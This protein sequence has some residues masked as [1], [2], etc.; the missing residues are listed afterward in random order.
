MLPLLYSTYFIITLSRIIA[1]AKASCFSAKPENPLI[2]YSCSWDT[3]V[4]GELVGSTRAE[5]A[6]TDCQ[7]KDV[8]TANVRKILVTSGS[9]SGCSGFS[10]TYTSLITAFK[11]ENKIAVGF[12]ET[13]LTIYLQ[14]S[15]PHFVLPSDFAGGSGDNQFFRRLRAQIIIKPL[16]CSVQQVL[17]C[18][19]PNER[20]AI[21]LKTLAVEIYVTGTFLLS[22][23]DFNA[24][25][26]NVADI[27]T[28]SCINSKSQECCSEADLEKGFGS[29]NCALGA[30]IIFAS[31]ATLEGKKALFTTEMIIDDPNALI[32]D[33]QISDCKFENFFGVDPETE[34]VTFIKINEMPAK[35]S[36]TR[37]QFRN[38]YFLS[39]F[40]KYQQ[41]LS[42]N[43][44]FF[45]FSNYDAL[46][47]ALPS[48]KYTINS[49]IALSDLQILYYNKM[50]IKT[51]GQ[52][53]KSLFE[54]SDWKGKTNL[55]GLVLS[56]L[57]SNH[58]TQYLFK[59]LENSDVILKN[60]QAS[61]VKN[62]GIVHSDLSNVNMSQIS[63]NNYEFSK[64]HCFDFLGSTVFLESSE[65]LSV[66][67]PSET[68]FYFFYGEQTKLNITTT[69]FI[70]WVNLG[71]TIRGGSPLGI[72]SSNFIN[73]TFRYALISND[74]GE[75]YISF[76]N[77]TDI[78]GDFFVIEVRKKNFTI[79]YSHGVRFVSQA[80]VN[81]EDCY[82]QNFSHCSFSQMSGLKSF[83]TSSRFFKNKRVFNTT[84]SDSQMQVLISFYIGNTLNPAIVFD[85][86]TL[87]N[88]VIM[89]Y[90]LEF[91]CTNFTMINSRVQDVIYEETSGR[92]FGV[93]EVYSDYF[94]INT[95]FHNVGWARYPDVN[96][97][98]TRN[99]YRSM[100]FIWFANS[101][102]LRDVEY[103]A[104]KPISM[105]TGLIAIGSFDGWIHVSGLK[106]IL[107]E[108]I[109]D[110]PVRALLIS[111]AV[112]I[113]FENSI[114]NNAACPS[115]SKLLTF[116]HYNGVVGFYNF[117]QYGGEKSNKKW[118][119]LVN[120]TFENC[121]CN[122]GGALTIINYN[123][124]EMKDCVFRN[125]KTEND[126]GHFYI[127]SSNELNI[128]NVNFYNSSAASGA[129]IF[130]SQIVNLII[131]RCNII[132]V[133]GRNSGAS[134]L[135]RVENGIIKDSSFK[136]L[137]LDVSGGAFF[138][139]ETKIYFQ[140]VVIENC[141]ADL[142]GMFFVSFGSSI[143]VVNLK[144]SYSE[145]N[146]GGIF[147]VDE[148]RDFKIMNSSF[149]NIVTRGLSS[150]FHVKAY[151]NLYLKNILIKNSTTQFKGTVLLKTL[152]ADAPSLVE[153][154][155]CSQNKAAS[156]TCIVYEGAAKLVLNRVTVKENEG[157]SA[158]DFNQPSQISSDISHLTISQS[159][160]SYLLLGS[161]L[162]ISLK[163]FTFKNSQLSASGIKL[164]DSSF[165]ISTGL[166]Q[167][168]T[169]STS[170]AA[171]YIFSLF[172]VK[173]K[174]DN[175]QIT[176]S[177][178]LVKMILSLIFA[179]GDSV[180]NNQRLEIGS[181]DEPL[182]PL[183]YL[184]S[185][186]HLFASCSFRNYFSNLLQSLNTNLTL[187]KIT[188]ENTNAPVD[189]DISTSEYFSLVEID[190]LN[191]SKVQGNF[192]QSSGVR[193]ISLRNFT[194]D[195]KLD[196]L[197]VNKKET[198]G[199]TIVDSE[200]ITITGAKMKNL[201]GKYGAAIK[202]ITGDVSS[203]LMKIKIEGS[204]FKNCLSYL[205]GVFITSG[206]LT[207]VITDSIFNNN[208]AI[209]QKAYP[210]RSGIGGVGYI[211]RRSNNIILIENNTFEVNKVENYAST[212]MSEGVL[213]E[214]KNT[215]KGNI[216]ASGFT[217]SIASYP[218]RLK[219]LVIDPLTNMSKLLNPDSTQ[220]NITSGQGFNISFVIEDS[221][222][223]RLLYD[224]LSL[225]SLAEELEGAASDVTIQPNSERSVAGDFFFYDNFP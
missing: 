160:L 90:L 64:Q 205:G 117:P 217:V 85:T 148:T 30:K 50:A 177:D 176:R 202:M 8:Q 206:D 152:Q 55:N 33:L 42:K 225:A 208:T 84:F 199:F 212:I 171:V 13:S 65:F 201:F 22:S 219:I 161:L 126:G 37:V 210:W 163:D 181:F 125:S 60:I 124:I 164:R 97:I 167:D 119:K 74:M 214:K 114:I 135:Y 28:L 143:D 216:D 26:S 34:I 58:E 59:L 44:D 56:T 190:V 203:T 139:E 123:Y 137:K 2:C 99:F 52:G 63:F 62:L 116:F 1:T 3:F 158:I 145:A 80:A 108:G 159:K 46:L 173:M 66:K 91:C 136:N 189:F 207:F 31:D 146:V 24:L 197:E 78:Q 129:G 23:I 209:V 183:I 7:P 175:I 153:D 45:E 18:F 187:Q 220:I 140:N 38:I 185:G 95:V 25:G 188:I 144:A 68:N 134:Y 49:I 178:P 6:A 215:F 204:E 92:C 165:I 17:G 192:F 150:V 35:V 73:A 16:F 77:F 122:Y 111:Y 9:C 48:T 162:D 29:G 75:L 166:F 67:G 14:G 222:G 169:K 12:Q 157:F 106:L 118:I 104:S 54:Y 98:I 172:N 109:T 94:F 182:G 191:A 132:D 5:I 142:G 213:N 155:E 79:E 110:Y 198:E 39:G 184:D 20:A 21:R 83:W 101:I 194:L 170:N 19:Q 186:S 41:F 40:I 131:D 69:N 133:I 71:I 51:D 72:R 96:P 87:K 100:I 224:S 147:F 218:L 107:K 43:D 32:P 223:Q 174:S 57:I 154:L 36:L 211:Q 221:L 200:Y 151:S 138:I 128:T 70:N 93:F 179:E 120:N 76:T 105:P 86:V 168:I 4:T 11:E 82:N 102:T 89:E 196:N 112:H 121:S 27:S 61:N 10:A 115:T 15:Q 53:C 103:T 193:N 141:K 113:T 180:T 81:I 47:D 156:G 130:L 149:I 195:G 88:I 127:I